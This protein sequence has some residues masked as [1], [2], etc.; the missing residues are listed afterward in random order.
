MCEN[1]FE[2]KITHKKHMITKQL[3]YNC[4]KSS[5]EFKTSMTCLNA[6]Q[7]VKKGARKISSVVMSAVS[8][9]KIRNTLNAQE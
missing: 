2:N 9:A 6:W 8:V 4:D 5:A 3:V 7:I 1:S